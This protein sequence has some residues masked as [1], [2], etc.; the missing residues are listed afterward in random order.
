MVDKAADFSEAARIFA[1]EATSQ[2]ARAPKRDGSKQYKPRESL[3][4]H[5]E[6]IF[7]LIPAA[8]HEVWIDAI[9]ALDKYAENEQERLMIICPPGHAKT[10]VAGIVYPTQRIGLYPDRHMLYYGN[11]QTQAEKQSIA[12]RDM[13]SEPRFLQYYPDIRKSRTKTWGGAMWYLERP[14]TWDKDP[15]MLALGVDGPALGARADEI[16]FDDIC[17]PENMSTEQQR[18]KVKDKIAA[19]AFSRQAGASRKTRMLAI[20]TRW[21]SDDI[22]NFFEKEGFK[23]IW[24]PALGYWEYVHPFGPV[25]DLQKLEEQYDIKALETGKALWPKEYPENSFDG[26]RKNVPDIWL[27]EFQGLTTAGGGNRFKDTDFIGWSNDRV[28]FPDPEPS[29]IQ[30]IGAL[31]GNAEALEEIEAQKVQRLNP[32]AINTVLQFWDTANTAHKDSDSWVCE[33]WAVASDGYYMLDVYVGKHEFPDGVKKVAE[34]K[35]QPPTLLIGHNGEPV[36]HRVSYVYVESTGTNNGAAVVQTCSLSPYRLPI[37]E[38]TTGNKSKEERADT[39]LVTF[40]DSPFYFT[41]DPAHYRG[42][43]REEFLKQHYDFPRGLHDDMVD[44]TVHAINRLG[45]YFVQKRAA[46]DESSTHKATMEANLRM[47]KGHNRAVPM[48]TP[49]EAPRRVQRGHFGGSTAGRKF[50]GRGSRP[51]TDY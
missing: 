39:A 7:G 30:A 22:A 25:K 34:L 46:E 14:D 24:M 37:T 17:D 4:D 29:V 16:I 27:L 2:M 43:T 19:V 51:D 50:G 31:A 32:Y 41:L 45:T 38:T 35:N 12:I 47:G 36:Q 5:M 6:A 28:E 11:T 49:S 1:E 23:T 15:T 10:T 8:H 20:M 18:K 48:T 42:T 33:T 26:Y 40:R 44:C 13:M 21:H 3:R 9:E